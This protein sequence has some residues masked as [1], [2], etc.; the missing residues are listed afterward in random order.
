MIGGKTWVARSV[1]VR[2]QAPYFTIGV[3]GQLDLGATTSEDDHPYAVTFAG[4]PLTS[5]AHELHHCFGRMH[6]SSACGAT[7]SQAGEPWP[8]DEQGFLN[9]VG[10]DLRGS[11]PFKILAAGVAGEAVNPCDQSI[12]GQWYDFMSYCQCANS[13]DP[14]SLKT[15]I[16][17][18]G[19]GE[20]WSNPNPQNL[21][22]SSPTLSTMAHT[23]LAPSANQRAP[24]SVGETLRVRA[25]VS[26]TGVHIAIVKKVLNGRAFAPPSTSPY[27]AVRATRTAEPSQK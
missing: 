15:W 6:A 22:G 27:I 16:S 5:V 19:W 3:T 21:G 4:R 26:G 24:A 8:P 25:Y 9:G 17:P 1:A 2:F 14:D 18:K 12:P 7:G 13:G 11:A 20:F 23:M 10:I